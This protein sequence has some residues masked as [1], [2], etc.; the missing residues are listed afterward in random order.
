[1]LCYLQSIN[2]N[3]QQIAMPTVK[4]WGGTH[5]DEKAALR[6]VDS[7]VEQPI[8]NVTAGIANPGAHE[9]DRRFVDTNLVGAFPGDPDAP[10]Y[11]KRRAVEVL[12]QS[13]GYDIVIDL[14]NINGFGGNAACVDR[15]LGASPRILGFLAMLDIKHILLTDYDGI[16]KYVP[17][18]FV[19]ETVAS[20]L[21]RKT[22]RLRHAIDRLANDSDLPDAT[23]QDFE[24]YNHLDGPH[25]SEAH[26]DDFPLLR[27]LKAFEVVPETMT[28]ALGY[29]GRRIC[30][31]SW[32]HKP[33]PYGYW[34]ELCE[35][36]MPPAE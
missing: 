4:V 9:L 24:W 35:P 33:N 11:E 8:P 26:P 19:L 6:V 14:H 29:A 22:D 13:A 28:S 17:N 7:L 10:E 1:M 36:T 32:R 5:P 21:G 30:F 31:M 18:A 15:N 23:P 20:G 12:E 3:E 34:S 16:Q 2:N 25:V 27:T